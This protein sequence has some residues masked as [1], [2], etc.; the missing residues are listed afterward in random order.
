MNLIDK[1]GNL[2][3]G[4]AREA[5]LLKLAKEKNISYVLTDEAI[6]LASAIDRIDRL[7]RQL[8]YLPISV[9]LA[10]VVGCGV[11]K[12]LKPDLFAIAVG[13]SAAGATLG[14]ANKRQ[15]WL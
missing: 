4:A 9:I 7:E 12:F 14:I 6:I 8:K 13:G 5:V 3:H 10:L 11:G 2:L 15:G 1:N